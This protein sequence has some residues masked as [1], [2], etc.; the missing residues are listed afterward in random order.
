M[1]K[2]LNNDGRILAIF[3]SRGGGAW[4]FER[5][6]KI[7]VATH[8][9]MLHSLLIFIVCVFPSTSSGT[10]SR[11][12]EKKGHRLDKQFL[13]A[14]SVIISIIIFFF[15]TY[16]VLVSSFSNLIFRCHL[17]FLVEM[18]QRSTREINKSF[19]QLERYRVTDRRRTLELLAILIFG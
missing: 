14:Q 16:C 12:F 13:S 9:L 5:T 3:G 4:V 18:K 19:H 15:L 1:T 2:R 8:T 6:G 10:K 11:N 7:Q 17:N